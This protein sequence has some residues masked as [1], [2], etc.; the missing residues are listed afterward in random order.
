MQDLGCEVIVAEDGN[1]A[2]QIISNDSSIDLLLADVSLQ[3]IDGFELTRRVRGVEHLQSLPI[4]VLTS[5][6]A[7]QQ[8]EKG[9]E[10]GVNALELKLNKKALSGVLEELF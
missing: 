5:L 7:K 4:V 3:L 10:V 2:W 1:Q 9:R 6:V 8:K